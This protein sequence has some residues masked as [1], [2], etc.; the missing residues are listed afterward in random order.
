MMAG[1]RRVWTGAALAAGMA[2]IAMSAGACGDFLEPVEWDADDRFAGSLSPL[3]GSG[4]TGSVEIIV[5][6]D[7]DEFMVA[8]DAAGLTPYQSHPQ[9]IHAA[10]DCPTMAHDAN[11]D[12][13]LD[14]LEA[15]ETAGPILVAL[16]SDLTAVAAGSFPT[17]SATGRVSYE[18]DVPL[19]EILAAMDGEPLAPDTR[20]YM[21][22]GVHPDTEL[23][24][25]VRTIHSLP[26]HRTLPV[27]CAEMD[28]AE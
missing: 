11:D 27:A 22:H 12:R 16:D 3:N 18:A 1:D 13:W 26:A 9:H 23:P 21:I 8:V 14:A 4:V 20:V 28:T 19:S 17:S 10:P 15:M 7:D 25:T 5:D 2:A 24:A 6:E